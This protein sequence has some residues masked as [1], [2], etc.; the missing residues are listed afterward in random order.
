MPATGQSNTSRRT[1]RS[2]FCWLRCDAEDASCP[3]D[4]SL[5]HA[6][7][8]TIL[9]GLNLAMA[10]RV[11]VID[12]WWNNAAEQ[13]AFCRVFRIGQHEATFMTRFC[14]TNTV[15]QRLM[16]MQASKKAEIDSVMEAYGEK[17]TRPLHI[18]DLLRLFGNLQ[19]DE[20]GRPFIVVDNPDPAG[21]FGVDAEHEVCYMCPFL[22]ICRLIIGRA[23][24]MMSEGGRV[25]WARS[26]GGLQ[27]VR[28]LSMT[29]LHLGGGAWVLIALE[30]AIGRRPAHIWRLMRA[31]LLPSLAGTF[32]Y[33]Q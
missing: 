26:V 2:G 22:G 9:V 23:M 32:F 33:S 15:D 4:G 12:P 1:P 11:I 17:T 10:S 20:A 5:L 8:D 19:E 16:D 21:G 7:T 30:A 28:L 31:L 18:K 29:M 27:R 6:A 3:L 25:D 13:Q 24:R 14:V